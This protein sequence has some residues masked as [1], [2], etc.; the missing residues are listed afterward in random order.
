MRLVKPKKFLGQHFLKDL[1]VAQ[2]IAD[3][4]DSQPELPV[5]EVGPGMGVLTQFLVK[6][7]R[8]VKVVEV[9]YESVAYLR[10]AFPSLEDH[11]IEDDFLKMNLNRTFDGNPF[12]LTGNYPY[13]I[14]SQIF[15]KMLDNKELIPC[16]TGMIQK[17]VA[18]RIAAGPGSKTYGILSVLI[19]AW[20]EVEYLFTVSEHVFNPP[21]KVKS[22]VIRMTRNQTR[23]LGC[24]EKLFKQVVKTTFN[25]RRK[26]L[27]NSIKPILGKESS[28]LQDEIFNKRPEQLSVQQF[29]ELTNMVEKE[30]VLMNSQQH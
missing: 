23:D 24:N 9:D 18:E 15:F 10:E 20:Y 7:E 3:T 27:R 6:K 28:I 4:V 29:V 11:I 8:T 17:E 2:D 1:K 26:T 22:A 5:L 13:N 16:C 30:L 19:Q 12:V 14:S 25:Q 21:P